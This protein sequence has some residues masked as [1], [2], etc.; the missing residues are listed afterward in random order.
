MPA[1]RKNVLLGV[2]PGDRTED[3]TSLDRFETWLGTRPTVVTLFISGLSDP[4][5]VEA[6]VDSWM[7]RTWNHSHVPLVT[8]EPRTETESNELI[9][10]Q[11]ARGMYDEQISRFA[12]LL[13]SWIFEPPEGHERRLFFRP[14]HEMNGDW[15]PWS[16]RDG[17]ITPSDYVRM[18]RHLRE[19]FA[20][21][22]MIGEHIQWMWSVNC[23]DR[24]AYPAESFYPGDEYVDWIGIDGYNWGDSQKWSEWKSPSEIYDPMLD[25]MKRLADNPIAF[26]EL[27]SSSCYRG[28]YRASEK[29]AWITEFGRYIAS[30]DVNLISWFNMD[31]NTDWA[32]FDGK[33]GTKTV[34]VDGSTCSTYPAYRTLVTTELNP[35]GGAA[36]RIL[37]DEQFLGKF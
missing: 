18:W 7:T 34:T 27:A 19:I 36:P 1:K 8:W 17:R 29:N 2:F 12:S 6:F 13:E 14:A 26:P 10:Q 31:K 4:N 33:N 20:E 21:T 35:L 28:R 22:V 25:R 15:Y 32:V 16:A 9:T 11:I 3:L 37:T 24:L 23:E 30:T 5:R